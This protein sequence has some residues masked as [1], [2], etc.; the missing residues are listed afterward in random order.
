MEPFGPAA[1]GRWRVGCRTSTEQLLRRGRSTSCTRDTLLAWPVCNR[2]V[3]RKHDVSARLCEG[4]ENFDFL[5]NIPRLV[6][7]AGTCASSATKRIP[8]VTGVDLRLQ[9]LNQPVALGLHCG[10]P[11]SLGRPHRSARPPCDIQTQ[12]PSIWSTEGWCLSQRACRFSPPPWPGTYC[13]TACTVPSPGRSS[14]VFLRQ[15]PSVSRPHARPSPANR[16]PCKQW[17]RRVSPS[18]LST[19]YSYLRDN[20]CLLSF[21]FPSS[22]SVLAG[23]MDH[24]GRPAWPWAPGS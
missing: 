9:T 5:L 6:L 13:Y 23:H 22:A 20:P 24:G 3:G 17:K 8:A 21:A 15:L 10:Q 4:N 11:C 19:E 1:L 2:K 16:P 12:Q 7:N 14:A 18:A